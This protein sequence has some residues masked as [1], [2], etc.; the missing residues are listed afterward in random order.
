MCRE[1]SMLGGEGEREGG[2]EGGWRWRRRREPCLPVSLGAL[3][4]V[5]DARGCSARLG[6]SVATVT[7]VKRSHT[8]T[9]T[10]TPS[11]MWRLRLLREKEEEEEEASDGGSDGGLWQRQL[12]GGRL[13]TSPALG[14]LGVSSEAWPVWMWGEAA[15]TFPGKGVITSAAVDQAQLFDSNSKSDIFPFWIVRTEKAQNSKLIIPSGLETRP[16]FPLA[17]GS[18]DHWLFITSQVENKPRYNPRMKTPK[19]ANY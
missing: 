18:T 17:W 16:G 1:E 12:V 7:P 5:T 6:G 8:H 13:S 4:G 10:H 15:D 3:C 9:H 11:C 14:D 19:Q 2:M